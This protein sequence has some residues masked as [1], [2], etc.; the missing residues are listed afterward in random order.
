MNTKKSTRFEV[1]YVLGFLFTLIVAFGTFFLGFRMGVNQTE[2]KYV[3][4]KKSLIVMESND[5]SYSQQDLVSFYYVV[6]QPYLQFKDDYLTRIDSLDNNGNRWADNASMN[7]I[8]KS[9]QDKYDLISSYSVSANSPL[10]KQAHSDILKSLKLFDE[11]I[12]R[13][14]SIIGNKQGVQLA[15]SV[16][17]DEF[18]TNAI[19]YG[20]RAQNKFYTSMMKWAAKDDQNIPEEY[21]FNPDTTVKQWNNYS[22]TLKNKAIAD[23]MLGSNLYVS[24]MPQDLTAKIDQMISSGKATALNL[25]SVSSIVK[26]VTE[27]GAVQGNDFIKWKPT[28]YA[29]ESLPALPFFTE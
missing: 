27:T 12:D 9:A 20:L 19:N 28:Y 16:T 14:I 24:Y 13:N 25:N 6:Y 21:T 11:G 22:L 15:S 5:S 4:L 7:E 2:D 1:L 17:S 8:R 3:N 29:S 10:L 23:I 18:T 26:V